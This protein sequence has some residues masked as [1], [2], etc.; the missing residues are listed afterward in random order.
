M[1]GYAALPVFFILYAERVLGLSPGVAALWLAGF[2]VATGAA[3]VGCGRIRNPAL[4]APLVRLGAGLMGAGFLG[5]ALTRDPTVVALALLPAAI[6]FG[7]ISALG[8]PLLSSFIPD[9]EEGT[10]AALFSSVRSIASAI[11][12]P[13]AGLAIALTD[14]YRSLFVVGGLATLAALV[15]LAGLRRS[16]A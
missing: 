13:T 8:F 12:L 2:G 14:S 15:P 9:G 10:Y 1:L 16:P 5:V 7:L 3:L 4:N 11:A 6:G